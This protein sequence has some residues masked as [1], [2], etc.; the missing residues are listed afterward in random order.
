ML[1]PAMAESVCPEGEKPSSCRARSLS[2]NS[3]LAA[4]PSHDAL[5]SGSEILIWFLD[6]SA[7]ISP[8]RPQAPHVIAPRCLPAKCLREMNV[9]LEARSQHA[10]L[11]SASPRTSFR[12]SDHSAKH[13]W[14]CAFFLAVREENCIPSHCCTQ[15]GFDGNHRKAPPWSCTAARAAPDGSQP[16]KMQRPSFGSWTRYVVFPCSSIT[17]SSCECSITAISLCCEFQ[18][19][20]TAE[21]PSS[22]GCTS[23][24]GCPSATGTGGFGCLAA[25]CGVDGAALTASS[26]PIVSAVV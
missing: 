13:V 4:V 1:V 25:G 20:K 2:C 22:S 3:S 26:R 7:R 18:C 9:S 6:P 17:L 15:S 12:V 24:V 16:R 23:G 21:E 8:S 11:P 10:K 14:K 5:S 19:Q